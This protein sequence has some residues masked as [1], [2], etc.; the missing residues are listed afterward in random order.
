MYKVIAFLYCV[1]APVLAFI[2]GAALVGYMIGRMIAG[3]IA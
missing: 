1:A 2:G 3:G